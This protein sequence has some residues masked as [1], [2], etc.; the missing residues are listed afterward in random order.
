MTN[1]L[2]VPLLVPLITGLL[3]FLLKRH[4]RTIAIGALLLSGLVSGVL[5]YHAANTGVMVINFGGWKFP[6]AIQLAGDMLSLSLSALSLIVTALVLIYGFHR[7]VEQNSKLPFI[8]FLLVGVN[9]SFLTA[10]IFNL[11]VQFEIMLLSS[12]VLLA[13]GNKARQFK[14]SITYVVINVIGSWL[15]LVAIALTY[16]KYGTLSFGHLSERIETIGMTNDA[17]IIALLFLIVFSL[18]SALLLFMWL[19]SSYAVLSTE[20][21]AIFAALM[22]KVGVYSLLRVFTVLFSSHSAITHQMILTMSILT[23]II[24]CIGVLAYRNI[25][26][27]ACYQVIL[28]IGIIIFGLA[29]DNQT[30]FSGA[31]LYLMN[32]MIIK[33]LLFLIAGTVIHHLHVKTIKMPQGFIKQ[34]PFLG[35]LLFAVTLTLGGVPPFGGFPG[36]LMIIQGGIEEHA[37]LST[38]VMIITSIISMYTLLRMFMK[39]FMGEL[40]KNITP[41]KIYPHQYIAMTGL[42]VLSLC[43]TIFAAPLLEMLHTVSVDD[44]VSALMEGGK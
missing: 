11:Y 21:S 33:A 25:K 39:V 30:G 23:M 2:L 12:F 6:Y 44:Y 26:Y 27:M 15:F 7:P 29:V 32:D 35:I 5:A 41:S 42:L 1:L 28:S 36:K 40:N 22:T 9:G 8:L 14:A 31:A 19:P 3:L 38:L 24:G 18:K 16:R 13:I 20:N 17:V 4:Q 43:I 10:D 37:L 34:A